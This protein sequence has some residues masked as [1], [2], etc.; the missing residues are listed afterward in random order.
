MGTILD[1]RVVPVGGGQQLG[2]QAELIADQTTV[3]AGA[4][5]S[6]VVAGDDLGVRSEQAAAGKH[7]L[8]Q[9]RVQPH[10]LPLV[11]R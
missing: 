11:Q 9:V 4:V 2:V 7:P 10:P 8:A 3:V 1:H 6:L 5:G